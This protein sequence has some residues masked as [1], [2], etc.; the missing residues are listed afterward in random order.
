M[1]SEDFRRNYSC[2]RGFCGRWSIPNPSKCFSAHV[3]IGRDYLGSRSAVA[4]PHTI[5][6]Q[7]FRDAVTAWRSAIAPHLSPAT[8]RQ[9]ESHLRTRILP[10]FGDFAPQ[11]LG[12]PA[13]QQFATDLRKTL[14]RKT[15]VNVLGTNLVILD[16]AR[17][18]GTM[19]S[20]VSFSDIERGRNLF[21][22]NRCSDR[23]PG[24]ELIN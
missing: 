12:I 23:S 22:W 24:K 21:H 13:L 2:P 16:Y 14:S 6:G 1:P 5:K 10:S 11:A 18:C 9:R 20:K 4:S 19:V 17:R 3:L 7:I 8:V 15:V